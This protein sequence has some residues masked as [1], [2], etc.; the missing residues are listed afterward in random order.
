MLR[1]VKKCQQFQEN[2]KL[3]V[4]E[5]VKKLSKIRKEN[6]QICYNVKMTQNADIEEI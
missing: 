3:V 5:S 2:V 4:S 1:N 6:C